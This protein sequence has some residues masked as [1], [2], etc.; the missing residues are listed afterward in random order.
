MS[1]RT[2][3]PPT[4]ATNQHPTANQLPTTKPP[5]NRQV[6]AE[7]A[8]LKLVSVHVEGI[9]GDGL[10]HA[11]WTPSAPLPPGPSA[12]VESLLRY[13]QE[14]LSAAGAVLP[15]ASF[16]FLL[17]TTLKSVALTLLRLFTPDGIK[18]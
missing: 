7:R 16:A 18:R 14:T 5:T 4:K 6:A 15:A 1:P 17:R 2:Q 3:V 13:M 8:L 10:R 11:T 9:V 12:W